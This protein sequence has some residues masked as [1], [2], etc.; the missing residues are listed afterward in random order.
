MTRAHRQALPA[1]LHLA[2]LLHACPQAFDR[3]RERLC[4]LATI[5][6]PD[7]A[8]HS[9]RGLLRGG[10]LA[11]PGRHGGLG[12]LGPI[13]RRLF[14]PGGG[15]DGGPQPGDHAPELCDQRFHPAMTAAHALQQ[16]L[17]PLTGSPLTFEPALEL[18]RAVLELGEARMDPL[19]GASRARQLGS[20]R[21]LGFGQ[22]PLNA[23]ELACQLPCT[24]LARTQ[25]ATQPVDLRAAFPFQIDAA[26][27]GLDAQL[28][29]G[30]LALLDA[31]QFLLG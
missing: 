9:G 21:L 23:L 3:C 2:D 1:I 25:P 7:T 15:R 29:L 28:L 24:A 11:G 5:P 16:T 18:V 22:L 4:H 12:L 8:S 13:R 19:L 31:P 30:V 20:R 26:V 6:L 10:R 17:G 14:S 27:L